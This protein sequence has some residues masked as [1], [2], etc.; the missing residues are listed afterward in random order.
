M[1]HLN[2]VKTAISVGAVIGLYHL[3]WATLVA[4]GAAKAF[5]DFVLMLHFMEIEY[6]IAPFSAA[7]AAGLV[8]LTFVIGG[9]F[10]LMFAVVWNGL[11]GPRAAELRDYPGKVSSA[12]AG[13]DVA[14][15]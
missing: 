10:G 15:F 7:I 14:S 2:P 5:L 8:G 13:Q 12:P 1:R 4:S 6:Q 3:A 9:A 11:A